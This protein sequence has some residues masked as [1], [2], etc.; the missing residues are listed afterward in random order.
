MFIRA[1]EIR[2]NSGGE[3]FGFRCGFK[4]GLNIIR[5]DNTSGKSTLVNTLMYALGFEEL[6]G[7]KGERALTSAVRDSFQFEGKL[8]TIDESAVLVELSNSIDQIVTFRRP[9]K[10]QSKK[11]KLVEAFEAP[12]LTEPSKISVTPKPLFLHDGGAAQEEEGFLVYFQKFLGINLP[13]VQSSSG[14][15]TPLYPQVIAAALFIEQK[16]GWTDYIANIPFYR[17]LSAPTRVVQYLLG[18]DNFK[19]EADKARN[20]QLIARLGAEWSNAYAELQGSLR[21]V[22]VSTRGVPKE[23]SPTF[24]TTD[25]SLWI[26]V[27]KD[28]TLVQSS[29]TIKITEWHAIEEKRKAGPTSASPDIIE[30][31][32]KETKKLELSVLQYDGLSGDDRLR[33]AGIAELRE[34][35]VEAES[36]L[37]KN[38][39]THKL[40][41]LGAVMDLAASKDECPTC[42]SQVTTLTPRVDGIMPMD[43]ESNIEYLEA[44]VRMLRRQISGLAADIE[45][46][47][48]TLKQLEESISE[49][50]AYVVSIRRNVSQSDAVLEVAVRRQ[51]TLEREIRELQSAESRL[52]HFLDVTE[53]LVESFIAAEAARK[54]FP[55]DL[56]S[57]R[58]WTKIQLMEK[59]FRAN[60]QS[61][62]YTSAPIEEIKINPETLMPALDDLTLRQLFKKDVQAESS[63]SDFVRLVWA[64]LLAI[65]QTSNHRDYPGNHPG[66]LLFDEP[67]QHSMSWDSQKA[68]LQIMSGEKR[69]QSFVAASFDESDAFF[70]EVTEGSEFHLITL[71]EKMIGPLEHDGAM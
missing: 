10:S 7:M 32:D 12:L 31:L 51:V 62:D 39:T 50:R 23:I 24:A 67:G 42:G 18:T 36:D 43:V 9:I 8:R 3:H 53:S 19:V 65:Y 27:G 45:H 20:L 56:Y 48:I 66:V 63:A 71:P 58:D 55:R 64:Y 46:T 1:V 52:S 5:G 26:G 15:L 40:H 34:L 4:E 70:A 6:I 44:Q 59:N 35:L 68:L 30:L 54:A 47:D 33:K 21:S 60:A 14:G 69:L 22:G 2:I 11:T 61:F 57:K 37:K 41:E 29:L 25:A 49:Q 13:K 16:R 38:K 28:E 17:I